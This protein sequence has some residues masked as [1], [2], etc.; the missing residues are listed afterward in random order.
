MAKVGAKKA[1]P[2]MGANARAK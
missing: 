1:R 2:K